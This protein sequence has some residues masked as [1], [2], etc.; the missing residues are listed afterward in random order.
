MSTS[1]AQVRVTVL[2]RLPS[3]A[4]GPTAKFGARTP[5]QEIFQSKATGLLR[6]IAAQAK[7]IFL[8]EWDGSKVPRGAVVNGEEITWTQNGQVHTPGG[9][10]GV[11]ERLMEFGGVSNSSHKMIVY[12][13]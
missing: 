13:H 5:E 8:L 11:Y 4:S 9:Q 12:V 6:A 1:H 2:D 3:E 7:G 10:I